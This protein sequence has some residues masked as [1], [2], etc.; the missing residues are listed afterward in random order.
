MLITRMLTALILAP[1]VAAAILWADFYW[2][3]ALIALVWGMGAH[4]WASL[5][6]LETKLKFVYAGLIAGLIVLI[7]WLMAEKSIS[8]SPVVMFA[9]LFWATSLFWI[10]RFPLGFSKID[11]ASG[12]PN[13]PQT[14]QKLVLGF[15]ILIPAALALLLLKRF[16]PEHLLYVFLLVWVADVGAYFAGRTLG[17]IKMVP[18]V[19]PGKSWAGL[20]GG[21]LSVGIFA[22]FAAAH[23]A[24]SDAMQIKFT[25]LALIVS[26]F[27]VMGDLTQSMFKRHVAMKD[28]GNIFPGHGGILDRLDSLMAAAPVYVCGLYYLELL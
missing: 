15:F 19:S 24:L 20:I 13:D 3:L 11:P 5:S 12:Q 6:V 16:D 4:E 18:K 26:L 10:V 1:L 9:T 7:D 25:V 17:K 23:F 14:M 21:V 8:L 2:I 28:S 22:W 27:S